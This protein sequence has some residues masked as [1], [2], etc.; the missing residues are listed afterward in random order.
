MT[1]S[2]IKSVGGRVV[3]FRKLLEYDFKL[4]YLELINSD[5][6]YETAVKKYNEDKENYKMIIAYNCL[7]NRYV[8]TGRMCFKTKKVD[9]I[10]IIEDSMFY[11]EELKDEI[12][13]LLITYDFNLTVFL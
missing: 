12:T 11:G 2:V 6:D 4:G 10:H 8:G 13:Q 3:M 5:I 1:E 7:E 9:N